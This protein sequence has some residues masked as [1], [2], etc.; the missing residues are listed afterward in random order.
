MPASEPVGLPDT[1]PAL[2]R[3]LVAAR[4]ARWD[5]PLAVW[6]RPTMRSTFPNPFGPQD[7]R[8]A[9]E[10]ILAAIDA[11]ATIGLFGDYDADG[12]TSVGV[13]ARYLTD[14]GITTHIRIPDRFTEGYG[15]NIK[16][17]S[18]LVEKDCSLIVILDSG[19]TAFEVMDEADR[20]G[21]KAVIIDHHAC[22]ADR[23]P[24]ALA[25]VNPNR[26]DDK[27][28]LGYLCAAGL[29]FLTCCAIHK[30]M[31]DDKS[32]TAPL[33]DLMGYLDIAALGT[34]ADIVPLRGFNRTIVACGLTVMN[35]R[36]NIGMQAL[37]AVADIK[38]RKPGSRDLGFALGPR[39]NAGGR[40]GDSSIG[41]RLMAS[42]DPAHAATLAAELDQ[43]N[44]ER[45][46][47]ENEVREDALAKAMALPAERRLILVSG[48]YHE[49]VVGITAGRIKE[50]LLKPTIVLSETEHGTLK[51]SGRSMPGFDLGHAIIA[52]REKGLLIAGG[53][54]GMAAGLTVAPEQVEA[55]VAF[56]EG[57]IAGSEFA[58]TGPILG[59]DLETDPAGLT[60]EIIEGLTELEP[61]GEG[62]PVP[63]FLLSGLVVDKVD[64][65]K[66]IH[67]RVTLRA[68]RSSFKA[69]LFSSVGTAFAAAIEARHGKTIDVIA[70]C[71]INEWQ[72]RKSLE[73]DII[74]ARAS[75][76]AAGRVAA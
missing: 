60:V 30:L 65:V 13:M 34:V 38:D 14:L 20:L 64:V 50:T 48:H 52:A 39:V 66:E 9:A 75:A 35:Q 6:Y 1:M 53:G 26:P 44:V 55:L 59:Y 25:F 28:G 40:I 71:S 51:G 73:L 74:D 24:K 17:L 15:P 58:R 45:K 36:P 18:E 70:S 68:G 69:M 42:Q 12:A 76:G 32:R 19:S 67:L 23:L 62:N 10:T 63:R 47:I 29:S 4:M 57:E 11:R 7:M 22:A 46:K 72:G 49:G 43:L 27:S 8:L 37:M 2:T 33:P 61:F 54:H 5:E 31:R 3:R 56:L 16:G 21:I 41:A